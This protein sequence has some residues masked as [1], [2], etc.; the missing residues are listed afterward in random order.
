MKTATLLINCPDKTGIVAKISNF[1]FIN[2]CNIVESDQYS[3][4][5]EGGHFFMRVQFAYNDVHLDKTLISERAGIIATELK[6]HWELFF[7]DEKKKV[8]ILVSKHDHCLLD[9]LYR[10]RTGELFIDIPLVISNHDEVRPIVEAYGIPYYFIPVNQYKENQ[11]K[12]ILNL[13]KTSTDVLVLARYMQILTDTFLA[14]YGK[15]II[16]IHHSFLPSFKGAEPYKQAWVKGVKVIGATA[17]YVSS[18]LDEG[19]II[20]QEVITVSH[21]DNVIRLTQ[22]GRDIEK[23]VMAQALRAHIDNKIIEHDNKTIVFD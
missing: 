7:D 16:N 14:N 8:G 3:T 18:Q 19:S 20:A 4:G 5:H 17:H 23:L 6:A 2:N 22:K 15:K 9:I 13:V 21:K 12:E 10:W 11:E 1:L